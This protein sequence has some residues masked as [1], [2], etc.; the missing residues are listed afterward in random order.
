MSDYFSRR[1]PAGDP[2][3]PWLI[4]GPFYEDLSDYV[5]G[6]S[7]FENPGSN[8]A[9][10]AMAEIAEQADP[11]L[12]SSP[13]ECHQATFRN[14]TDCWQLVRRPDKYLSWGNYYISNHLGA[15]FLSN[16]ITPQTAGKQQMHLR[17]AMSMRCIVAVNGTLVYD[18]EG[19]P[20]TSAGNFYT[21]IRQYNFEAEL[22]AGENTV[23]IGLFRIARMAQVGCWL[24]MDEDVD[25]NT[26]MTDKLSGDDRKQLEES[27]RS[28]HFD[29]DL[30]Y[31]EDA[32]GFHL[33][34]APPASATLKVRLLGEYGD[35]IEE[36]QAQEAGFVHIGDGHAVDDGV[37]HILR[38]GVYQINCVFEGVDGTQLA[39]E[40]FSI[41]KVTPIAQLPGLENYD[42]RIRRSLEH[43]SEGDHFFPIWR[44]VARY[45]LDKT[46]DEEAIRETCE[47]IAARKDCADF[48]IQ[49]VLRIM[50]WEKDNPKLSPQLHAMMK[51]TVLGFK[52]WTDEPGDTVMY[53]DSENHRLLFHVAE[54]LAGQLFPT[55]EF[56]NS[57]QRGLFHAAKARMYITEWL[58][59]RGRFG[60]DE[61]HSNSYYPIVFA[62][63]LNVYDFITYADYKV[64]QMTGAILDY[65]FF[66]LA[67]DS[68]QG[69]FGTTH[70]RSYGINI[71]YPDIEGTSP[72]SWL[73]YGVGSMTKNTSGMGPVCLASSDY[74]P[75]KILADIAT[76]DKAI[77]ES[78]I[79]QGILKTPTKQSANFIVYRTPD[80]MMSGVQDHRK[81]EFE[82]S[83]H[84][85]HIT[86]DNKMV[87]FWSCP[88]TSGEG[89]GLR[90]DYWSGHT[91]L[92]RVIQHKNVMSLSWQLT[93]YNWMSHCF[94]EQ[95]RFDEVHFDGNWVFARVNDGYVGIYSENGMTVGDYGQYAGRELQCAAPENTWLVECGRKSDWGAFDK[96]VSALKDA[97]ITSENGTITYESP[98]VGRFVTGWDVTP[99]ISDEAIQL[100]SYPMVDSPWAYSKFGSGEMVVHYGD[101]VYELWFN[102]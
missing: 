81:G 46:V 66:N 99:T 93:P 58:R 51:D 8:V 39:A 40:S 29:R 26:S 33:D 45:A 94:F 23:T 96:F 2:I 60:F 22:N 48:V 15:V 37:Y 76:D 30:F 1:V 52:Y 87:I 32:I 84:V 88:H 7:Y 56:T 25:V 49:G 82:S 64:K 44:E 24:A 43:F 13:I 67:A 57:R 79:R 31:P 6:L 55:E 65:M 19:Q 4:L 78:H 5:Q 53:M 80:Y 20:Y 97:N 3:Q 36:T 73:L 18:S 10:S 21:T 74:R 72:T 101:Q 92:P 98:S 62:P 11:I 91:T 90:P 9:V 28:I 14:R 59:Q 50:Y 54:L 42:E 61:W 68:Y 100:D 70:G 38:D 12:T 34:T 41:R 17:T 35:V 27:V 47:F 83:S 63:L 85:A 89:S 71:K 95:A 16:R 102:Q 75:P 69:V 77:V 86:L